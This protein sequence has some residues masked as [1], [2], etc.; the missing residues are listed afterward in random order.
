MVR[1]KMYIP[2]GAILSPI[3]DEKQ[4]QQAKDFASLCCSNKDAWEHATRRKR[5]K[6]EMWDGYYEGKIAEIAIANSY[7]FEVDFAYRRYGDDGDFTLNSGEKISIKSR[8]MRDWHRL[9]DFIE[10]CKDGIMKEE[11]GILVW[12]RNK[13]PNPGREI[14]DLSQIAIIGWTD[15][16]NFK[17][18]AI[19]PKETNPAFSLDGE[20]EGVRWSLPLEYMYTMD[21]FAEYVLG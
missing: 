9:G 17:K 10:N 11:Y 8:K 7:G 13:N 6:E 19:P 18:H 5:S 12:I 1:G 16:E 14:L 20:I 2:K 4:I 15:K 3:T 21:C